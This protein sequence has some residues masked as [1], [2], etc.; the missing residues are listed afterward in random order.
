VWAVTFGAARRGLGD[1][2]PAQSPARCTKCNSRPI[3]GQCTNHCITLYDGPLLCG[4]NVAIKGLMECDNNPLVEHT[5]SHNKK[6]VI[7]QVY[8]SRY[9][10]PPLAAK[11]CHVA[12]DLTITGDRQTNKQTNRQTEGHRHRVK[13]PH[14]RAGA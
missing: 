3:N 2:Q 11:C 6:V 12:N 7:E 1:P 9:N 4:F 8:P 5:N 10:K 14:S 13:P